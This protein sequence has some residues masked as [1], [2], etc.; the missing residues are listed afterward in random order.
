MKWLLKLIPHS[1]IIAYICSLIK[2]KWTSRTDTQIDDNGVDKVLEPSLNDWWECALNP[3]IS[4]QQ[5]AL[6]TGFRVVDFLDE[7]G[8]K[9]LE[10]HLKSKRKDL[11]KKA[12]K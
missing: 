2:K 4:W 10:N 7:D 5:T 12:K 9:S 11:P 1:I 3:D 8:L 6:T